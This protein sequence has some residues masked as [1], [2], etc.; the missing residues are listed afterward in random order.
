MTGTDLFR[1][2][3]TFVQRLVQEGDVVGLCQLEGHSPLSG[4]VQRCVVHGCVRAV[5]IR[6]TLHSVSSYP[7]TGAGIYDIAGRFGFGFGFGFRRGLVSVSS[8]IL[9]IF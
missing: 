3:C 5:V 7:K 1:R 9:E 6:E 2:G 4:K 8:K